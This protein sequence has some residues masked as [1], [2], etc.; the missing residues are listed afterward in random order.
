MINKK[1]NNAI[2]LMVNIFFSFVALMLTICLLIFNWYGDSGI[3]IKIPCSSC[4]FAM[5][6]TN[7]IFAL[8]YKVS[9][10]KA[11][12]ILF[13]AFAIALS[14]D[15]AINY[16]IIPGFI[17][18]AI[19]HA[20]FISTFYFIKKF[21]WLDLV[22]G[23]MILI[24]GVC[25]V[26]FSKSIIWPSNVIRA[27]VYLYLVIICMMTGKAISNFIL[28][29]NKTNLMIMIGAIL[30]LIS[31]ALL[32]FDKWANLNAQNFHCH[33]FYYPAEIVLAY[34]MYAFVREHN[35]I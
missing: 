25:I 8:K 26:T 16:N 27:F 10:I 19:V 9:N 22:C 3:F 14:A 7:L 34:S 21:H 23:L 6:I 28:Q 1:S 15:I 24:I 31:D 18:F 17:L 11:P 29:R 20:L 4:F 12:I 13:C 33:I 30:F 32:L 5:A 2:F 35:N